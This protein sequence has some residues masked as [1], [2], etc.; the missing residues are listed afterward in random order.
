MSTRV[1]LIAPAHPLARA[2]PLFLGAGFCFAAMDA[3]AKH[4]MREHALFIVVWARY[5]G[6]MIVVTPW[7]WHRSGP[8]FWRTRHPR[9]QLLRSTL[10]FA[11]TASF[12]AAIRYLPLAEASAIS[13]VSPLLVVVLAP[14]ILGE[15]TRRSQVAAAL[16][17]FVGVLILLRPGGDVLHP[18]A[19]LLF[20]TALC[21]AFYT[22]LTRKLP[23]DPPHTTIFYSALVGTA[24]L[25]PF[26]PFIAG[27]R[28]WM[29]E[30][31]SLLLL[32]GLMGGIGHGLLTLAFL[33]APAAMLA[34]YTYVQVLWATIWGW[35]AFS[36]LPDAASFVGMAVI[37]ASGVALAW[38]ERRRA[39]AMLRAGAA[40]EPRR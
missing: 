35:L 9:V 36:Q 24:V 21:I 33:R 31:T 28:T 1:P 17:G 23:S 5:A 8:V 39:A 7:A 30:N 11:A 14:W 18:A 4:L 34:P 27:P 16:G 10:L 40:T 25:T 3:L 29:V 20:L 13:F 2:L 12:Y 19:I 6:Q 15:T 38:Q 37:A 32:L 26:V 22:L